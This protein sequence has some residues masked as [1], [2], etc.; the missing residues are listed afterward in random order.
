MKATIHIN[1]LAIIKEGNGKRLGTGFICIKPEWIITA[2]HV[3]IHE[4]GMKKDLPRDN[5]RLL[6][7]KHPPVNVEILYTHPEVD[8]AVLKLP[9]SLK[10]IC[11]MPLNTSYTSL[12]NEK[13]FICAGYSP[14]LTKKGE[15]PIVQINHIPHFRTNT[16]GRGFGVEELI[17]F[18]A[19][20]FEGGNSGGPLLNKHGMIVGIIIQDFIEDEKKWGRAT[21]LIPLLNDLNLKKTKKIKR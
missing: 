1:S 14:D 8:I 20:F 7:Q 5:L 16:R 19:P 21:S 15:K 10:N 18:Q 12:K 2:K 4:T 13:E 3:V 6:F 17:E 11:P 9:N